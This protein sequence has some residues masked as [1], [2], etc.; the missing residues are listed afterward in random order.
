MDRNKLIKT[1]R[2]CNCNI[3]L[4]SETD[5]LYPLKSNGDGSYSLV[6]PLES[7]RIDEDAI[8]Q[9]LTSSNAKLFVEYKG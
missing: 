5:Y 6:G 3:S 8:V 1:I 2:E 7:H 9:W 4:N